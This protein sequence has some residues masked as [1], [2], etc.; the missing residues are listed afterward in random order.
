MQ[1]KDFKGVSANRDYIVCHMYLQ[2]RK[3]DEIAEY[4]I[5]NNIWPGQV[6]V[7]ARL[8]RRIIYKH[9]AALKIDLDYEKI[10]D[11]MR[12]EHEIDSRG[13]GKKDKIDLIKA[14]YDIVYAG[15]PL[16]D[17]SHNHTLVLQIEKADD[18]EI[19]LARKTVAGF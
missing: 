16:V 5:D 9:R 17:Q 8:C 15:K 19:A 11:I 7:V 18:K 10:K 14:K 13:F 4:L 3:S 12:I 6:H 1:R 2:G